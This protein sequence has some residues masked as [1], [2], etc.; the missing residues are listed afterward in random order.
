[1]DTLALEARLR[2]ANKL[3]ALARASCNR[4]SRSSWT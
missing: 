2:E 4:W 3:E 1:M